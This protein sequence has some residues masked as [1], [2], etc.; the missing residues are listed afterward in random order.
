MDELIGFFRIDAA[1]DE[2][3]RREKR[4]ATTASAV[5]SSKIA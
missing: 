1:A 2:K 4:S 3:A 5:V